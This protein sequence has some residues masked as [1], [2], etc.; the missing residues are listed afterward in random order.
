MEDVVLRGLSPKLQRLELDRRSRLGSLK[1]TSRPTSPDTMREK[2]ER[3]AMY[4]REDLRR[5]YDGSSIR[6]AAKTAD[7]PGQSDWLRLPS[8][9]QMGGE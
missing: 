8:F 9:L 5:L 1:S 4:N 3:P 6:S 7:K 2:A